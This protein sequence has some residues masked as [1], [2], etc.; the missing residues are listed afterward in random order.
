MFTAAQLKINE[1]V[2]T[3]VVFAGFSLLYLC[4]EFRWNYLATFGCRLGAV[5]FAFRTS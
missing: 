4:E 1:D 5:C 2:I 3:L